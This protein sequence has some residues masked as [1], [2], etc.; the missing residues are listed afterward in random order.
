MAESGE[1]GSLP[2][3]EG[4]PGKVSPSQGEHHSE[5][6]VET[7]LGTL[8][9]VSCGRGDEPSDGYVLDHDECRGQRLEENVVCEEAEIRTL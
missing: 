7:H 1:K 3:V 4:E 6:V 2:F 9:T 8:S 5:A